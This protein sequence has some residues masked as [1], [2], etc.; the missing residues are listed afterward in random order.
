M[1]RAHA[2]GKRPDLKGVTELPV[3][4]GERSFRASIPRGKGKVTNLG[5]YPDVWLAAFAYNT[6]EGLLHG[7]R[8]PSNTIPTAR[9]PSAEQ[10]RIITARVR[11]RLGIDRE[12]DAREGRHPTID[13]LLLLLEVAVVGFWR[14]QVAT[15]SADLGRELDLA[16]R[17]LVEAARLLFWSPADGHPSPREALAQLLTTRLGRHYRR[18][19][20]VREVLDDVCDDEVRLARWLVYPD[21]LPGGGGFLDSISRL[22]L[23]RGSPNGPG[24]SAGDPGWASVLG[25][26]PPFTSG[27]VREAYRLRSKA[28]HPDAGGEDAEF[29]RLQD[30][31]EQARRYCAAMG[32]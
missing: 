31:Y 6:A 9:Q 4:Q 13:E 24:N 14:G 2:G 29:V 15:H 18:S 23:D 17:R 11:K 1:A 20:L 10:V 12:Q 27:R 25:L 26:S 16:A 5:L 28:V 3:C 8:E 19:D 32:V 30:A 21:E 22:Y 7:R